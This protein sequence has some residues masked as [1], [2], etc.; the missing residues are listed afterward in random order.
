MIDISIWFR[1]LLQYTI[2]PN[3]TLTA[4]EQKI[5]LVSEMLKISK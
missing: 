5:I 4:F 2:Y 3:N 1:L